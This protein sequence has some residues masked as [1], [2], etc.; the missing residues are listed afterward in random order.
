MKLLNPISRRELDVYCLTLPS[1][2]DF[3]PYEPIYHWKS[4]N[5]KSVAAIL[6]DQEPYL[7]SVLILRRRID[8]R[9]IKTHYQMGLKTKDEAL[10]EVLEYV[11]V[12]NPLEPLPSGKPKR[13]P[14]LEQG[15]SQ[16]GDNFKLL[17]E[18]L[19]HYPALMTIGETYLALPKPD[20]NFVTDFQTENFDSRL[21]ELYLLAAFREQGA[22]VSQDVPSPDFYIERKGHHCWVEAVTANSPSR[23]P[24]GLTVPT[25][26][27]EEH[28]ERLIGAP[29]VR[30]AKTLRSKL[31]REYEKLPHVSGKPFAIAIADFHAPSSM[32]WS[33]EA[34]PSFLY[35]TFANVEMKEEKRTA[36]EVP[37]K[38]LLGTDNIPAGLF[39]NPEMSHLSAVIFSNAAT[40]SKFN[41]MGF[42][43]GWRPPGLKMI[44]SGIICDRTPGAL[45]PIKFE[46]DVL[47]DEYA[48]LW[49]WG[50]AWCQEM[51]VF[52][53]PNAT[54]PI[55]FDL[56]PGACHWFEEK[57]ERLYTTMWENSILSS[58]TKLSWE[59]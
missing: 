32:V 56:L 29:A 18:T 36:V 27:P 57:G 49:P 8:S 51:E 13:A 37:I 24:Q 14:L 2:P 25:F 3:E 22:L 45:D 12:E 17:T 34:L 6:F 1:G 9:F 5:G 19:S 28:Q 26:A 58:E 44:R 21:F 35:G 48:A 31:Q 43:A 11:Q 42:L 50:E 15:K 47:S 10:A 46:F 55:N 41:R 54:Y 30:Y 59:K 38:T 4:K 40:F 23:F 52:H 16:I 20:S 39:K 33:R 7:F 53:N